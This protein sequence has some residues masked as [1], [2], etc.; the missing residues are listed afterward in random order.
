VPPL[1]TRD[2]NQ[3]VGYPETAIVCSSLA[4]QGPGLIWLEDHELDA[5]NR[6]QRVFEAVTASMKM[7]AQD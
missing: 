7:R 5:Y 6:G 1:P 4:C 2:R 3:P